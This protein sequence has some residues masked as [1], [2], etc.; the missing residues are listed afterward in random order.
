MGNVETVTSCTVLLSNGGKVTLTVIADMNRLTNQE[1]E[2]IAN[3]LT[4]MADR[5]HLEA[6]EILLNAT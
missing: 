5:L 1:R 2:F 6:E 3:M 4:M